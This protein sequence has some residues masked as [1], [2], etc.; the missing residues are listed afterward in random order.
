VDEDSA[1][2][3]GLGCADR[4]QNSIGQEICTEPFAMPLAVDS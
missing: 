2:A 3:D 4:A 1:H